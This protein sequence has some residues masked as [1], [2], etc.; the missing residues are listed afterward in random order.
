MRSLVCLPFSADLNAAAIKEIVDPSLLIFPTLASASQARRL[1]QPRWQLEE[2]DFIS[3]EQLRQMLLPAPHPEL[4]DEKR[5]LC[6]WQVLDETDKETFHLYC[7]DDLVSWGQSFL[8]FFAEMRDELV[9]L[10]LLQDPA[11]M[12]RA[13]DSGRRSTSSGC[14]PSGSAIMTLYVLKV[15]Q[16]A[17]S[18]W[19]WS[20]L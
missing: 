17:S 10:E 18:I 8:S 2:V 20:R 5:L 15:S 3:M 9:D 11:Q 14:W 19:A 1:F 4:Q 16:T 6:L 13:P 7:Y 12:D